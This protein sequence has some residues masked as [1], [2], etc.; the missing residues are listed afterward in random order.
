[1]FLIYVV[2]TILAHVGILGNWL[3]R[4]DNPVTLDVWMRNGATMAM[5]LI[6]AVCLVERFQRLQLS[7]LETERQ[8]SAELETVNAQLQ[9]ELA[10]RVKMEEL[11]DSERKF[12]AIYEGSNDAIMLLTEN[13]FFDCNSRTLEMLELKSKE[14][15]VALHPADISPPRQPDGQL[16]LPAA[17]EHI[18]TAYRQGHDRF[19][20][21]H[22]RAN[23]EDFPAEVLLS[24]FD[25]GEERVLQATV[26]DITERKRTEEQVKSSEKLYRSVIEHI[27]D[28]FY[29][30]D[31]NGN[32]V[33][34]SPSGA[35]LLDYPSPEAMIGLNIAQAL[36]SNP[37]DRKQL[38]EAIQKDGFVND[39]EVVLK[40]SDGTPLPISV[41]SHF[42][43]ND[44]GDVLGIEGAFRDITNRTQMEE[45]LRTA[46]VAADAANRAKSEFLASMSHELR[47]PLNAIIGFS[48][49][50]QENYFGDLNEKQAEYVSDI[51]GSGQHLLSLINDVLDLSKIESGKVELELSK[52]KIGNLLE[53]SL[54]MIKEKA[55]AHRI[56]LNIHITENLQNLVIIADERGIKQVMFNLL[57]NAAK[58]TPDGGAITV[59]AKKEGQEIIINVSD[60][61]IGIPNENQ[62]KIFE[63][64]Y[65]VKGSSLDKTPGTGLGLPIAR[66]IVEMHGGKIWM[67][68]EGID[69]GSR[70]AFTLPI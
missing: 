48:Q 8:V 16:S 17:Q 7:T 36:Y 67:E 60:T 1:S 2:F 6:L 68:S 13:G 37:E 10:Q 39:Y 18:Q 55:L 31:L 25:H 52:V 49:V 11:L 70:F 41:S 38:L 5:L 15:F 56:S 3:T 9:Q 30:S 12:R 54:I 50:L 42:Y 66:R 27:I 26:R 58:F 29:R 53:S 59:E 24:A 40:R 28:V 21:M 19:E 47:T 20:W 62:E 33:L 57:S 35:K 22:R 23:G 69:K 65:Q 61:G 51:L 46:K 4:A 63:E 44:E 64:F 32:L 34:V 43:Y 45:E 14:E